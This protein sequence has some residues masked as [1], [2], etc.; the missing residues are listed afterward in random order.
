MSD[1]S[2]TE[3]EP[4]HTIASRPR[5]PSCL[6]LHGLG[7][8]PYELQPLIDALEAEGLRVLGAGIARSRRSGTSHA[9]VN[10]ARLGG[11]S[12]IGV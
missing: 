3:N 7:G 11:R 4:V 8:G 5:K 6:V 9:R 12:R 2:W 1:D 10:L